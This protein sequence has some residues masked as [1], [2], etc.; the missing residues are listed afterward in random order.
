[1]SP[2][3]IEVEPVAALAAT[4]NVTTTICRV[5]AV[6]VWPAPNAT[7]RPNRPLATCEVFVRSV[8]PVAL[9]PKAAEGLL[10]IAGLKLK[11]KPSAFSLPSATN[12]TVTPTF[13]PA[14]TRLLTTRNSRDCA[15]PT[16]S[17]CRPVIIIN[18]AIIKNAIE[19]I[20]TKWILFDFM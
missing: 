2:K 7:A 8:A 6:N 1:M 19:A 16:G 18:S 17:E 5:P 13:C 11:L 4:V 20:V 3:L 14:V 15:A 10:K 12:S 9:L